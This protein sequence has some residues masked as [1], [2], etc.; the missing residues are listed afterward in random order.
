MSMEAPQKYRNKWR[1]VTVEV[2][3]EVPVREVLEHLEDEDLLEELEKRQL[4]KKKIE[5]A[6]DR[7][8]LLREA[9]DCLHRGDVAETTLILERAL[10]PKFKSIELCEREFKIARAKALPPSESAKTP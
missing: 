2:D 4:E 1:T 3:A 8:E 9:L 5:V 6:D 7:D 10:F